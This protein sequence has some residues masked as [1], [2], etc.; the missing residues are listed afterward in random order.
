MSAVSEKTGTNEVRLTVTVDAATFDDAMNK[1]YLKARKNINIP[2]FRKGKAPRKMIETFYSEAIFYEDAVDLV[3]PKAYD[4]AINETGIYPVDRPSIDVAEIG[5]GKDL[6]FTCDVTVKPEVK[7]GSYKGIEATRPEYNVTDDDI[8]EELTKDQERTARWIEVED[9]AIEKGDRVTMDYAGF[10]DGEQFA[11]GT[12]EGQTLEIGS[13]RFIP[14]FEDQLIGKKLEEESAINVT[15]PA[16]Y[17]AAELAGKDAIFNVKIHK[18]EV[19]E[20]PELN[21]EFAQDVSDSDTLD[22]YKGKIRERLENTA[23]T[24]AKN[25]LDEMLVNAVVEASEVEIPECMI[26]S[27]L[28]YMLQEME[29]RMMY[30]GISM[31]DYTRITGQT[32]ERI[33]E[34]NREEAGKIVKRQ[35][36]LEA[37]QKD[38]DLTASDED[39]DAEI[40]KMATETRTAEEV[41]KT[42]RDSDYD[43]IKGNA[44]LEKTLKLLGDNAI[45]SD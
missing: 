38:A 42:L 41:K 1:A 6:V 22:A 5:A 12:A 7:L 44:L 29:Y 34:E 18:I 33:R 17:Q 25:E 27:Q 19:K 39:L 32:R 3:F 2:G 14:G 35:L 24:R 9:R 37:V 28:D 20:L 43:Y 13:G 8:E 11:G 10:C 40:A 31:E 45:I 16:E 23:K 30:Q 36:V 15:F 4:D 26:N 21:D